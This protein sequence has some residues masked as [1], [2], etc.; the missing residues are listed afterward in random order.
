MQ[1]MKLTP[2]YSYDNLNYEVHGDEQT[3]SHFRNVKKDERLEG[4][5]VESKLSNGLIVFEIVTIIQIINYLARMSLD[6]NMIPSNESLRGM[7]KFA[8]IIAM[9]RL[10][11]GETA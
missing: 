3:I 1:Y 11:H 8:L 9:H 2:F 6:K 7:M 5:I 10:P 4:I